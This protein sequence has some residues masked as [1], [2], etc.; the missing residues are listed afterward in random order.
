[1]LKHTTTLIKR[2]PFA[3][4]APFFY[5]LETTAGWLT[6]HIDVMLRGQIVISGGTTSGTVTGPNPSGLVP[7]LKVDAA[8]IPGGFYKGGTIFD[9]Q[10]RTIQLRRILDEGW[11][12]S[13]LKTPAGITGAAGTFPLL[14][15]YRINFNLPNMVRPIESAL[16]KDQFSTIKI[17]IKTADIPTILAGNDRTV[18][19]SGAF[20]DVIEHCEY[21]PDYWPKVMLYQDDLFVVLQAANKKQKLDAEL[22]KTEAY[23]DALI[24]SETTNDALADTIVNK[25]TAQSGS[26]VFANDLEAD[27]YKVFQE[28]PVMD[29]VQAMTGIYR[30]DVVRGTDYRNGYLNGALPDLKLTFDVNNPGGAGNDRL[31]VATRRVV[32]T[33]YQAKPGTNGA[34][35]AS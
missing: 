13:D 1:M 35:K 27:H 12:L 32:P 16:R 23:L 15:N 25:I 18:D 6:T 33:T 9:C 10:P 20:I 24:I 22:P 19:Y 31:I 34:K 4:N 7:Q 29:A 30:V 21:A 2:F 5:D 8:P 26:D 17:T 28:S 3:A 14:T 11:L